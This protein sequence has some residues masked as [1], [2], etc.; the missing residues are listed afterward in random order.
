M[1]VEISNPAAPQRNCA[2]ADFP[3]YRVS[4]G[5]LPPSGPQRREPHPPKK[6]QAQGGYPGLHPLLGMQMFKT[7]MLSQNP[8][9][10]FIDFE[11]LTLGESAE[12]FCI[13]GLPHL[14]ALGHKADQDGAHQRQGDD[15]EK[16]LK[17]QKPDGAQAH[18]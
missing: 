6:G 3:T 17:G 16:A 1:P 2:I 12:I 18:Q 5:V 14:Q 7:A 11:P 10:D 15:P 8:I 9:R 13:N 4:P